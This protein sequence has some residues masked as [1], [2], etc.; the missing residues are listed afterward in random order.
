[1]ARQERRSEEFKFCSDAVSLFTLLLL[2]GNA[3]ILINRIHSATAA[4][5]DGVQDM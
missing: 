1:M 5:V 2:K 3:A 4:P